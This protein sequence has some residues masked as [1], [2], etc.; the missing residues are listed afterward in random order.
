MTIRGIR[1]RRAVSERNNSNRTT[2]VLITKHEVHTKS[3]KNFIN[4]P[5]EDGVYVCFNGAWEVNLTFS[6]SPGRI[7]YVK[8]E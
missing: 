6:A 8:I 7:Y 3:I 5:P 2:L 1:I 4:S